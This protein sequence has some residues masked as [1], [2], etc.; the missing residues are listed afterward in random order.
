VASEA[1]VL[2]RY[3]ITAHDD[4]A[5][6]LTILEGL[7]GSG[8]SKRLIEA[9]NAARAAGQQ[10]LTFACSDSGPTRSGGDNESSRVLACREAGLTCALDHFVASI[11]ACG[12]L[13][14][15]PAGAFAAFEEAHCFASVI[16]EHWKAAALRGVDILICAPSAVQKA[17]LGGFPR[18]ETNFI[19]ACGHCNRSDATRYVIPPGREAPVA[20][21]DACYELLGACAR[22]AMLDQLN[23]DRLYPRDAVF[24]HRMESFDGGSH[25][26]ECMERVIRESLEFGEAVRQCIPAGARVLVVSKG[27]QWLLRLDGPCGV[28]FPADTTGR[29]R[30][31]HPVDSAEAICLLDHERRNGAQFIVFPARTVWWLDFYD[32]LREHLEQHDK[33]IWHDATCVVYQLTEPPISVVANHHQ[34]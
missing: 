25:R 20:I 19:L 14:Q 22:G 11:E 26:V 27:D 5:T 1:R 33:R 18:R 4:L 3:S 7:P 9:V 2:E 24:R 28:H 31:H 6:P 8:K 32:D 16:A 34:T 29:Y 17:S 12:I 21:C 10:T 15:V 13:D 30:G 23:R